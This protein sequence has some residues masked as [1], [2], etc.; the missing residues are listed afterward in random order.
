MI[1]TIQQLL[2]EYKKQFKENPATA[3]KSLL[4][5]AQGVLRELLGQQL[6]NKSIGKE[7][8]HFVNEMSYLFGSDKD[9]TI[10]VLSQYLTQ[11]LD[12]EEESWARWHLVD[13]LAMLRHCEEVVEMHKE[14]LLWARKNLPIDQLLWVMHDGTQAFCWREVGKGEEWLQIFAEIMTEVVPSSQNRY[15]RFVYLRTAQRAY[16]RMGQFKYAWRTCEEIHALSEEDTTWEKSFAAKLESLMSKIILCNEQGNIPQLRRI[17]E[18]AGQ[19]IQ[20]YHASQPEMDLQQ[21][22]D[23]SSL[24]HNLASCFYFTKQYDLAIPLLRSAIKLGVWEHFCYSWL[25][26]SLWSTTSRRPE[27]LTLLEEGSHRV[28]GKYQVW[29]ELPE[30]RDVAD[31]IEFLRASRIV[32]N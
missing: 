9:F 28:V 23:L 26:A 4:K 6:H 14:F 29:R 17:G 15:D 30:F 20:E 3:D 1:Q 27:V 7:A 2:F 24:Y 11:L 31:D 12:V 22:R 16:S 19:K 10:K 25:A 8:A 13:N 21:R 18:I 32:K 5:R